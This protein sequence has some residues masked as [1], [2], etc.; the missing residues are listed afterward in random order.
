MAKRPN[1]LFI[2]TDQHRHDH[3]RLPGQPLCSYPK[4]LI[5]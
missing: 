4:S 5:D 1:F 3:F 2:M